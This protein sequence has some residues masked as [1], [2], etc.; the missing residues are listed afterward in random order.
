MN[1]WFL[2]SNQAGGGTLVI[3]TTSVI[4]TVHIHII[5]RSTGNP[6]T[7]EAQLGQELE[8]RIDVEPDSGNKFTS[9]YIFY[10]LICCIV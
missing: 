2:Y 3:N 5:D 1:E 9:I 7:R 6:N 4:P 10:S 8:F